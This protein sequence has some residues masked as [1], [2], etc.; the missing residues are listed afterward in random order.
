MYNK[1]H[2]HLA[3]R[4]PNALNC[5]SQRTNP[6]SKSLARSLLIAPLLQEFLR[7]VDFRSQVRASPSI[8]MIQEH[9][10]SVI[11]PYLVFRKTSFTRMQRP[12]SESVRTEMPM[13]PG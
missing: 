8:G 3:M 12:W 5:P 2:G 1:K 13:E 11:L 7:L 10:L 9:E 4:I 6:S